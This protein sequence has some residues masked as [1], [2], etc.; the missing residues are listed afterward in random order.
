VNKEKYKKIPSEKLKVGLNSVWWTIKAVLDNKMVILKVKN[1][2]RAIT[3]SHHEPLHQA[4]N[5][6][7]L[8]P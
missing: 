8:Q 6:N 7:E 4:K 2:G 3:Q 1:G 5:F